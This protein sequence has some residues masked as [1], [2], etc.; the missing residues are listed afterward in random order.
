MPSCSRHV[1]QSSHYPHDLHIQ[2][3]AFFAHELYTCKPHLSLHNCSTHPH[4]SIQCPHFLRMNI[5]A[6]N[7]RFA[8]HMNHTA[9]TAIM[10]YTCTSQLSLPTC[11]K[12]PHQTIQYPHALRMHLKAL[13][14]HMLYTWTSQQSLP[15]CSTFAPQSCH[16]PPAL[17]IH[18]KAFNAHMLYACTSKLSL[19]T[20]STH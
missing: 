11:S 12:H 14:N 2:H 1:P 17:N 13:I 4:K 19:P 8:L 10:L 9:V 15:S 20:C 6:I 3:L 16:Y 7:K 18:I 5:K